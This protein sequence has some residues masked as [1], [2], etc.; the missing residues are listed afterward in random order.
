MAL[1]LLPVIVFGYAIFLAF[2]SGPH[3]SANLRRQSPVINRLIILALNVIALAWHIYASASLRPVV[4]AGAVAGTVVYGGPGDGLAFL[5]MV[6]LPWASMQIINLPLA[7]AASTAF[8][9]FFALWGLLVACWLGASYVGGKM[10]ECP[11]GIV[12]AGG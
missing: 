3:R 5:F 8:R 7:W 9:Q 1:L 11:P 2:E 12:C 4:P 6:A 10:M